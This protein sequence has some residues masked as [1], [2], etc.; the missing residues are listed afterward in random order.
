M[1]SACLAATASSA[2]TTSS[3]SSSQLVESDVVL[4]GEAGALLFEGLEHVGVL[5]DLAALIVDR[6]GAG[7]A[8]TCEGRGE[9]G[10][11]SNDEARK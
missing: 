9:Y 3:S 6:V 1:T 7:D 4:L 5:L 11:G 8:A 10:D 2:A